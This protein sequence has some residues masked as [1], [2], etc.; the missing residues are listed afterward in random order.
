M[1]DIASI[2]NPFWQRYYL[3][4]WLD[5][6]LQKKFKKN[7]TIVVNKSL[8]WPPKIKQPMSGLVNKTN[9]TK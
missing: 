3:Y 2:S 5:T 4:V 8:G 1:T 7:C 6:K 9:W